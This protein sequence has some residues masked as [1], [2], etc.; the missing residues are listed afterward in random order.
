[1]VAGAGGK[2]IMGVLGHP[3]EG[4]MNQEGPDALFIPPEDLQGPCGAVRLLLDKG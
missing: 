3:T 2:Q 4:Q 1:M